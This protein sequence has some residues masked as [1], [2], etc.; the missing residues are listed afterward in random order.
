MDLDPTAGHEQKGQRPAIVVS[1]D[2]LD[3]Q[4]I[5]MA[6]IIPGTR[7]G[8]YDPVTHELL[9]DVL[10][11]EPAPQN[12]LT[13]IT[14]FLCAQ[15]RSVSTERFGHQRIGR[16]TQE[17]MSEIEDILIMLLDLGPD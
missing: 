6:I 14:Y 13:D 17:Q 12:G 1:S 4:G 10:R 9:P 3:L 2:R 8:K 16:L 5:G 15:L 7:T 11:V